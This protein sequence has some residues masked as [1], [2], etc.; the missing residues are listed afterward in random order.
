MSF[1]HAP[2]TKGLMLGVAAT[3]IVAGVFDVKH[4]LH[5]QLVPHLS[6]H[7]QYWRLLAHQLAF[8]NS[9]DLF[10]AELI[11]WHVG[12]HVERQFGSLKY[13][14]F[15]LLTSAL[16][17]LFSFLAL[18]LLHPLLR[19]LHLSQTQSLQLRG[20]P[21][22]LVFAILWQY[23][24]IVPRAYVFRVFGV[25]GSNKAFVYALAATLA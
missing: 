22:P 16:T 9:S 5:L 11:L 2:I 20:G 4:Y 23:A 6:Q 12:V 14:S 13:A 1:E 21:A 18:I 25:V 15:A 3:S 7:H 24:R 10:V 17:T 19:P 8:S